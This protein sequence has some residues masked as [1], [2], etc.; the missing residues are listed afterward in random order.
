M[1]ALQSASRMRY[2]S[3]GDGVADATDKRESPFDGDAFRECEA[4]VVGTHGDKAFVLAFYAYSVSSVLS[5]SGG[6]FFTVC[7]WG[8]SS[9]SGRRKLREG[10]GRQVFVGR[11]SPLKAR[12]LTCRTPFFSAARAL[13]APSFFLCANSPQT[14]SRPCTRR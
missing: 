13:L 14:L 5:W 12:A 11:D 8:C 4:D 2:W 1:E 7:A 3:G 10:V 6:T 9:L